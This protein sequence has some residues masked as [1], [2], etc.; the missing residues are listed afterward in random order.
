MRLIGMISCNSHVIMRKL[1][2]SGWQHQCVLAQQLVLVSLKNLTLSECKNYSW[3][4]HIRP[5]SWWRFCKMWAMIPI[6]C[7]KEYFPGLYGNCCMSLMG[8]VSQTL[9]ECH[10]SSWTLTRNRRVVVTSVLFQV[11]T[12]A[13]GTGRRSPSKYTCWG[14][15]SHKTRVMNPMRLEMDFPSCVNGGNCFPNSSRISSWLQP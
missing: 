7:R 15:N 3:S 1:D 2:F 12:Q 13:K 14:N 5:Q 9:R 4:C 6:F 10:L 11:N 8:I